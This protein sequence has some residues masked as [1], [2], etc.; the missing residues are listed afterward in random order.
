MD[1]SS[2]FRGSLSPSSPSSLVAVMAAR[3]RS[4]YTA[5]VDKYLV[6]GCCSLIIR[7]M[8]PLPPP[9]AVG[10]SFTGLKCCRRDHQWPLVIER[11]KCGC[12]VARSSS[13]CRM[14]AVSLG[15]SCR[16]D[17]D[18]SSLHYRWLPRRSLQSSHATV[19]S[20]T[21]VVACDCRITRSG[22]RSSLV[23]R[24]HY[25]VYSS[26]CVRPL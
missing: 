22:R 20:L 4:S 23:A 26:C 17:S 1:A 15:R 2:T 25:V 9:V 19:E 14:R 13:S 8:L 11:D 18:Y 10:L 21:A 6:V 16:I 24:R 7:L 3:C 12:R 5:A